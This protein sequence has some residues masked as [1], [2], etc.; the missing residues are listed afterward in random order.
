MM[1]MMKHM[2]ARISKTYLCDF[3]FVNLE[4]CVWMRLLS[5]QNLLDGDGSE[6]VFAICS[7]SSKSAECEGGRLSV[8]RNH[9]SSCTLAST[10]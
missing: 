3:D 5:L 8:I 1:M 9:L 10:L 7:L 2:N 4:F 6:G